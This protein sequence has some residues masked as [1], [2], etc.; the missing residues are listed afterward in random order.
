MTDNFVSKKC[1]HCGTVAEYPLPADFKTAVPKYL[2]GKPFEDG[3]FELKRTVMRCPKCGY[4]SF[5]VSKSIL[6]DSSIVSSDEYESIIRSDLFPKYIGNYIAIGYIY[7]KQNEYYHASHAYLC[8]AWGCRDEK[9][10]KEAEILLEKAAKL[11]LKHIGSA[12]FKAHPDLNMLQCAVDILRQIREFDNAKKLA[13]YALSKNLPEDMKKL[14]LLEQSLCDNYIYEPHA[15]KPENETKITSIQELFNRF[16]EAK[17]G[18]DKMKLQA[19]ADAFDFINEIKYKDVEKGVWLVANPFLNKSFDFNKGVNLTRDALTEKKAPTRAVPEEVKVQTQP[20]LK[21]FTKAEDL[22][23]KEEVEEKVALNSTEELADNDETKTITS[24]SPIEEQAE[25]EMV[26]APVEETVEKIEETVEQE[27]PRTIK[28]FTSLSDL[29]AA[30]EEENAKE[31]IVEEQQEIENVEETAEEIVE[32]P[33]EEVIEVEDEPSSED[34]TDIEEEENLEECFS[35]KPDRT[36]IEEHIEQELPEE[37]VEGLYEEDFSYE[38]SE[39]LEPDEEE[40]DLEEEV[41]DIPE[42]EPETI[43]DEDE[44]AL[45]EDEEEMI[46]PEDD[47]ENNIEDTVEE[48]AE[49]L[50]EDVDETDDVIE[51]EEEIPEDTEEIP[52]DTEE[53]EEETS[54]ELEELS[55]ESEEAPVEELDES[56]EDALESEDVDEPV[57]ETDDEIENAEELSAED[58]EE[59]L[60]QKEEVFEEKE[61][62]S[63]DEEVIDNEPSVNSSEVTE[64]IKEDEEKMSSDFAATYEEQCETITTLASIDGAISV[65]EVQS[66]FEYGFVKARDILNRMADDGLLERTDDPENFRYIK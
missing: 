43:E 38:A 22:R 33:S 21:V 56:N 48:E 27:P 51:A 52:E 16:A 28:V 25:K 53:E 7:E 18:D 20:I 42:E 35:E 24:T 29:K 40:T 63:V 46:E 54:E 64:E 2:D 55:E 59:D 34:D 9:R 62:N 39:E 45:S 11:I 8:A 5:D 60:E 57:D 41:E 32:E 30:E 13:A 36:V 10:E 44:N 50:E 3:N 26:D 37:S 17:A 61:E 14:F 15:F 19:Y 31:E 23:P 12:E 1:Y 47:T 4:A 58:P 66:L 49:K 6:K 65:S